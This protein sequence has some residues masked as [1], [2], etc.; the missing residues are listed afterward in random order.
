MLHYPIL[1]T[2]RRT[3]EGV[4]IGRRQAVGE[5][6]A[7]GDEHAIEVGGRDP[8]RLQAALDLEDERGLAKAPG[9]LEQDVL[10]IAQFPLQHLHVGLAIGEGIAGDDATEAE[11]IGDRFYATWHYAG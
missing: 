6:R 9:R 2:L 3:L 4:E 8:G 11:G 5:P 7:R 1:G 10:P